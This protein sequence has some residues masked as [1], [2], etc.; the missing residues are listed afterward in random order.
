MGIGIA[1]YGFYPLKDYRGEKDIFK[2]ELKMTQTNIVD[3]LSA[4]AV[5]EMGEGSEQTPI[6]VI[7]DAGDIKFIDEDFSKT[8][9]LEININEDIYA[10]I[11]KSVKWKKFKK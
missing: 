1:Y 2:R 9:P 11:L 4:A 6:A 10:P 3:S 7:E 5:Y 8:N